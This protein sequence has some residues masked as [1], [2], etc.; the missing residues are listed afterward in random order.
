MSTR[1]DKYDPDYSPDRF[2]GSFPLLEIVLMGVLAL[3]WYLL[4]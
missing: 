4:K 2:E 1:I 3:A